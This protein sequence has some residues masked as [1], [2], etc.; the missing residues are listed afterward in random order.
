MH[1]PYMYLPCIG[2]S[3]ARIGQRAS[4]AASASD[5]SRSRVRSCD[6]RCFTRAAE[7]RAAAASAGDVELARAPALLERLPEESSFDSEFGW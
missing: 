3:G 4:G 2:R 6:V 5:C 1:H 7:C